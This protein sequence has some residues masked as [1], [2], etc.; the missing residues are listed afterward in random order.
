MSF[1]G[2]STVASGCAEVGDGLARLGDEL[3]I[4][5]GREAAETGAA[6][7]TLKASA[8][9]T[10]SAAAMS[11]GLALWCPCAAIRSPVVMKKL[12]LE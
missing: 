8:V 7:A 1:V 9:A 4:A 5:D 10:L 3:E 11:L 6:P 12:G 2:E